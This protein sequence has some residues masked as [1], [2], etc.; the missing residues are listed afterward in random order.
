MNRID[1]LRELEEKI[2]QLEADGDVLGEVSL[3]KEAV[4]LAREQYGIGSDRHLELQSEYGGLLKYIG[5]PEEA[6]K[7]LSEVKE[8]LKISYLG[9][10]DLEVGDKVRRCYHISFS[11]TSDGKR[12]TSDD[13]EAWISTDGRRIPMR[14]EGKLPVG[15]VH[16]LLSG[17]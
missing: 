4:E 14:L 10:V 13:M 15:K 6:V 7:Q 16:C 17:E 5:K 12:K 9:E 3:L 11:F 8:L 2:R 1:R